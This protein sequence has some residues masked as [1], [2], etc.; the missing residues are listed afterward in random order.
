MV[1]A[2]GGLGSI[3]PC[4]PESHRMVKDGNRKLYARAWR[5][6]PWTRQWGGLRA[7]PGE[8][9]QR[10]SEDYEPETE[11]AGEDGREQAAMA[12]AEAPDSV[13]L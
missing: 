5:R 1:V 10:G 6:A 13:K 2:T 9:E 12:G 3:T 8:H 4:V 11:G 7:R